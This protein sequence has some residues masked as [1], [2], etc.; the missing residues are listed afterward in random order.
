LECL[1]GNLLGLVEHLR[2][3]GSCPVPGVDGGRVGGALGDAGNVLGQDL[4]AAHATA[5]L[6]MPMPISTPRAM[7]RF[8]RG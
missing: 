4:D 1:G 5:P 3:E 2:Q 7:W 6:L 8:R